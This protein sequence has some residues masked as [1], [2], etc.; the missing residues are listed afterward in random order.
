MLLCN[1]CLAFLP[2][3]LSLQQREFFFLNV[4]IRAAEILRF[5]CSEIFGALPSATAATDSIAASTR[6]AGIALAAAFFPFFPLVAAA[7][8][9][10]AGGAKGTGAGGAAAGKVA[11]GGAAAAAARSAKGCGT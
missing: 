7:A 8:A 5:F 6:A 1:E 2:F 4:R 11:A 9:A 3:E 10:A